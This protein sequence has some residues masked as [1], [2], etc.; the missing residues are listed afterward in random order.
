V[1]RGLKPKKTEKQK[2]IMGIILREA[3]AGRFLTL[4]ELYPMLSYRAEATYGA[5]R[6]S[7]R[8]LEEKGFL[9]KNQIGVSKQLVPT[10]RA[11]DWFIPKM[12]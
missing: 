12:S 8:N 1:T 2:E 7:I 3:G 10:P 4:T 11:Y 5:V 9:Q 6:L